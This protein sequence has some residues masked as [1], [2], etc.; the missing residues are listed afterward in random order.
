[1]ERSYTGKEWSEQ[2]ADEW[3]QVVEEEGV[4]DGVDS[5]DKENAAAVADQ[6]ESEGSKSSD[7]STPSPASASG[8]STPTSISR[9]VAA[10]ANLGESTAASRATLESVLALHTQRRMRAPKKSSEKQKQGVSISSQR[11]WLHYWSQILSASAPPGFWSLNLTP[12]QQNSDTSSAIK[13]RARITDITIRMKEPTGTKGQVVKVANV[14]L[15]RASYFTSK[16]ST[17]PP[18]PLPSASEGPI[19]ISLARYDDV[20]VETLEQWEVHTRHDE[21]PGRRKTGSEH[22][23]SSE[24]GEEV[25]ITNLFESGSW[26]TSKMVRR[27]ATF[28]VLPGQEKGG[29]V[30]D[31]QV[32]RFHCVGLFS[33]TCPLNKG[34]RRGRF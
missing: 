1:M 14:I 16:K 12:S 18:K 22:M 17:K 8:S 31:S 27:F 21:T 9:A 34:D 33:P 20:F 30:E 11:R 15:D 23:R 2:R 13:D 24:N 25:D 26:D 29:E 28:G 5:T 4:L 19:W 7:T 32:R 3:I 6:G 10:H